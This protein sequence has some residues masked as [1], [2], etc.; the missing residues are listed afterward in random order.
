MSSAVRVLALLCVSAVFAAAYESVCFAGSPWG[1]RLR[2]P[3][4]GFLLGTSFS[5]KKAAAP[6]A[7][8]SGGART[9]KAAMAKE[10]VSV[11]DTL[12][13]QYTSA[14]LGRIAW[15]AGQGILSS[16][17]SSDRPIN[18]A[19]FLRSVLKTTTSTPNQGFQLPGQEF[20]VESLDRGLEAIAKATSTATPNTRLSNDELTLFWTENLSRIRDLLENDM[21]NIASGIYSFPEVSI[22]SIFPIPNPPESV[23]PNPPNPHSWVDSK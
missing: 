18:L 13:V 12:R 5:K 15:F 17:V 9:F 20:A 23:V 6:N 8:R 1:L 11:P 2:V 14:M 16:W 3:Q 10:I 7:L 4:T 22:I 21:T 19:T